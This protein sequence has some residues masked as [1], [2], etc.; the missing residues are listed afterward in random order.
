MADKIPDL[1]A[2]VRAGTG[3]GA[4][5]TAR[6]NGM[7]PGVVYGG[8]V[9]PVALQLDFNKLL[10]RLRKGRFMS[11]LFNLK[12]EG[13]DDVRVIC[14]GVQRH[15][16]KDLPTHIDFMRLKRTSRVNIFLPVEFINEEECKAL[17]SGGGTLTVVRNEVEMNVL[18]GEIPDHLTIDLAGRAMG[19]TIHFSDVQLPEGAKP[20]ISDRD[21][22]IANIAAPKTMT[23]DDEDDVAADEVPATEVDGE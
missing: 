20:V 17:K 3:K 11:T 22:V 10:T 1:H 15:V 4:A 2:E 13:H 14:R 23:A 8:G 21:F 18:A 19:D 7:V 9:D 16:V 12:V 6:R 5:R